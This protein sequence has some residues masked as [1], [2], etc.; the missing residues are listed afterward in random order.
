MGIIKINQKELYEHTLKMLIKEEKYEKAAN[1]KK[2]LD[3]LTGD[4]II[5]Y[6]DGLGKRQRK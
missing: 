4:E 1:V 6:D 5:E 2:E 3:K